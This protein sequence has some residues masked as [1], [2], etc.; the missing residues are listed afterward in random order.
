MRERK[1]QGDENKNST[2]HTQQPL[3]KDSSLVRYSLSFSLSLSLCTI[4]TLIIIQ[5][6]FDEKEAMKIK[7]L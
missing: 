2:K 7:I 5:I 4:E 3:I 1:R 6:Q